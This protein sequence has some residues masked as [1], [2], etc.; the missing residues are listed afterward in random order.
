[1]APTNGS[2]A[3]EKTYFEQ[4]RDLLIGDVAAVSSI[5]L[6]SLFVKNKP[7]QADQHQ[8]NLSLIIF[9]INNKLIYEHRV[10]NPSSK[11]STD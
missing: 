1:M 2:T 7:H 5:A 9:N 11:I 6:Q 10:S 8:H 4:Q 3:S